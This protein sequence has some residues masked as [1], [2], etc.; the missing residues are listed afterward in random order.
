MKLCCLPAYTLSLKGLSSYLSSHQ[1]LEGQHPRV[2][3][4]CQKEEKL[5]VFLAS[6][7]VPQDQE[8]LQ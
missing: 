2:C 6:Q 8:D 5:R 4:V 3:H 1:F 7:A